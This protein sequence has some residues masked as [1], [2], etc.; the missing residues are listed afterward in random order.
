[1][2]G[3][4]VYDTKIMAVFVHHTDGPNDYDCARDVPAILRTIE[5]HHI[6]AMGWDDIGYNFAV[7]RCGT[8]YEGR[9]GGVDRAV[10]G[11]HT[12]G[13]NAHSVGIAALGHFGEGVK[14]P[15]PMLRAI[16]AIAAWKLDPGIDPRG[17]VRLVSS[18]NASRFRKGTTADLNVISGHRDVFQTDCPGQALYDALPWIRQEAAQL[19]RKATWA[20]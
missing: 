19:R 15:R 10:M 3:K 14:V 9:A 18:N 13:F 17:R 12:E 16:A 7:D 20:A 6:H 4:P 5:D 11:A 1:M 8:I 2:H